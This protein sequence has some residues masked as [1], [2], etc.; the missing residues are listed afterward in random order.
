MFLNLM[1]KYL[2]I[3]YPNTKKNN[4]YLIGRSEIPAN[5]FFF[6]S[7]EKIRKCSLISV[8]ILIK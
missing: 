8:Q 6:V 3:F 5:L 4:F 7:V 2:R 1:Y